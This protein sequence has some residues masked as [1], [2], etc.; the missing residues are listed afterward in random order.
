MVLRPQLP[1]LVG[2]AAPIPLVEKMGRRL[3]TCAHDIHDAKTGAEGFNHVAAAGAFRGQDQGQLL[4]A[5]H[6]L[7]PPFMNE[8]VTVQLSPG[9]RSRFIRN[10]KSARIP[11][12]TASS[13]AAAGGKERRPLSPAAAQGIIV[14]H[15]AHS[16]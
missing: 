9:P 6:L 12:M 11:W 14:G 1:E 10:F 3:Q 8:D 16:G 15:R 4:A 5:E 13:L 7:A 2:A